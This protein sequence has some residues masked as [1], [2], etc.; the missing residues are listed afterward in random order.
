MGVNCDILNLA[1]ESKKHPAPSAGGASS[2]YDA[3][4]V[5]MEDETWASKSCETTSNFASC[6]TRFG[7]V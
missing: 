4:C 7:R 2:S 3:P 5:R 6:T 1:Q